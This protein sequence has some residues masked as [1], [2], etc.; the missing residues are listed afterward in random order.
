MSDEEK[1]PGDLEDDIWLFSRL[2]FL[3][4]LSTGLLIAAVVTAVAIGGIVAIDTQNNLYGLLSGLSIFNA[5]MA[6]REWAI[7]NLTVRIFTLEEAQK[8]DRMGDE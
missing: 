6:G 8:I 7:V 3:F 4:I 2:A 1:K 5:V